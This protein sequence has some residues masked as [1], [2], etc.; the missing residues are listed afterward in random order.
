MKALR[1]F[2]IPRGEVIPP[3]LRFSAWMRRC[4]PAIVFLVIT[5]WMAL[6]SQGVTD[7][8]IVD[9]TGVQAAIDY[10]HA[11]SLHV[12]YVPAGTYTLTAALQF[13]ANYPLRLMG[14]GRGRTTLHFGSIA[15]SYCVL[16]C[17]SDQSIESLAITGSGGAAGSTRGVL[18]Q[19]ATGSI[20]NVR[21]KDTRIFYSGSY[22]VEVTG[23]SGSST[24]FSSNCEH[25]EFGYNANN[26]LMKLDALVYNWSLEECSFLVSTGPMLVVDGAVSVVARD[27]AFRTA[28]VDSHFVRLNNPRS[29][30]FE[31][32][33]FSEPTYTST[34][35]IQCTGGGLAVSINNCYFNRASAQATGPKVVSVASPDFVQGLVV[36]NPMSY[37]PISGPPTASDD[38]LVSDGTSSV[39][40]L[41]GAVSDNSA[42]RTP[43]VNVSTLAAF[44]GNYNSRIRVPIADDYS[45]TQLPDLSSGDIIF[46]VDFGRLEFYNGTSW[47][48]F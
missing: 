25:C 14:A 44:I 6:A 27:C 7:W 46:N 34:H 21:L 24:V 18:I 47:V 5:P 8:V 17:G 9:A 43:R 2:R 32:C 38:V 20:S 33:Y 22:A 28:A 48:P 11:N 42:F 26:G 10:A 30:L 41:G 1:S 29:V 3:T 31:G 15:S 37:M 35:F 13:P 45:K 19:P 39:T 36:T 16:M 40:L 23:G 12:V 4:L